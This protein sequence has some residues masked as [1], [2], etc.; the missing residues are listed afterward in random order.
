MVVKDAV[1]GT[2]KTTALTMDFAVQQRPI[3]LGAIVC[4]GYCIVW[5]N[6][7]PEKHIEKESLQ[8]P[9][10]WAPCKVPK[11]VRGAPCKAPR[12]ICFPYS[13]VHSH[14]KTAGGKYAAAT[15]SSGALQGAV[16][17]ASAIGNKYIFRLTTA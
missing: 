8:N 17:H 4:D 2:G 16:N 15:L 9:Y 7:L 10:Y 13:T 14:L 11:K 6:Y 5:K 12:L 1:T 3:V